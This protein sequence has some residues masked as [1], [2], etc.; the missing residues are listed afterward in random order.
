MHN[1]IEKNLF[2]TQTAVFKQKVKPLHTNTAV[3]AACDNQILGEKCF[4]IK[5][6]MAAVNKSC[7][8]H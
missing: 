8:F 6:G 3:L 7:T 2:R 5:D 4:K 1:N